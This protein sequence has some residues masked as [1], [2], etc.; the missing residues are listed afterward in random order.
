M[1][2]A[3][4]VTKLFLGKIM[5]EPLEILR[6]TKRIGRPITRQL[7]KKKRKQLLPKISTST[8]VI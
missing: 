3:E 4:S 5:N 8:F 2:A 1:S 7:E 6:E